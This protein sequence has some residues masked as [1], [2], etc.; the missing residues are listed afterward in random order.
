MNS[1]NKE[2]CP[3][4]VQKTKNMVPKNVVQENY[5]R[6]V[7][8]KMIKQLSKNGSENV[9]LKKMIEKMSQK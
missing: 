5:Q 9:V 2:K 6:I 8:K 4:I 1:L 7:T 3:N